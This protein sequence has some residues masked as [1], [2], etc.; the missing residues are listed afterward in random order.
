MR[1]VADENIPLVNEFF[2]PLG[3]VS[4]VPGR[5][6]SRDMLMNADI[7]LVR[8]ITPVNKALLKGTSVKFVAT[9][10]I[11]VDHID[12]D[13]LKAQGIG[14]ANAPGSNASSV[15]EYVV[16]CLDILREKYSIDL[17]SQT[18]GII[19]HGNVGSG[20][21]KRLET[22]G[23]DCIAYDPLL[24]DEGQTGL[25]ELEEVLG[26]DIILMHAPLTTSGPYPTKHMMN[27]SRLSQLKEGAI[28]LNA[29]RGAVI[30]NGAL[31]KALNKGQN[32]KVVL[33]VWENEPNIS[34]ELA[35]LIDIATPHIAGYSLDGKMC[36]TDMIYRAACQF[37]GLPRRKK[38]GQF[39]PESP[40]RK[41]SFT[42]E[43]QADYACSVAI[44]S[45]YDV[46][47]DHYN[48]L[49]TLK[50][51]DKSS[52]GNAFDALRKNYPVRR[53]FSA[54]KTEIRGTKSLSAK[55]LK[56]LGFRVKEV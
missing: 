28:L 15:V 36:G 25:H 35:R 34:K 18:V 27:A 11:G 6:L 38:L 31:L 30:D 22:F 3:E 26:R 5:S 29:G 40:L 56:A 33:D 10:T 50:E 20:V 7:L 2:S 14:F 54:L 4:Q 39:L 13:Y 19:G 44:R 48:L 37:L 51:N 23:M 16:S 8:S 53:E 12:Q 43:V 1:I 55:R 9:A 24:K 41:M 17:L 46:R 52:R 49:R 21:K 42:A 32:L 47:R 45:I